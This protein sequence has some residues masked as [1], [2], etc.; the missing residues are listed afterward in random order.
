MKEYYRL[1]KPGI[2][3]GNA[4]TVVAGFI[5]A[6]QG[7]SNYLMLVL[8]VIGVS[9]VIASGCVFNN[10]FDR[11]IDAKMER[12]KNR[13]LVRGAIPLR[14]ALIYGTLLGIFGF[15]IL[16]LYTNIVTIAVALVGFLVYVIAYTMWFKRTTIY[17]VFVGSISGAVPLV[18]GYVAVTGRID[19]GAIILFIILAL[20][21]IPH[22]LA[23]SLYRLSDYKAA[24]IAVLPVAK[25]IQRTKREI[26][27]Y[28]ILFVIATLLLTPYGYTSWLY[29]HVMAI[30]G[31][32]F[33]L[34]AWRGL[35]IKN[36][37]DKVWARGVFMF[38]I[39][40]LVV[41]CLMLIVGGK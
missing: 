7:N 30:I 31:A 28:T 3:Y 13:A 9:L 11:D 4:I 19:S 36:L 2:V 39:F 22:S 21:Q 40:V 8:T 18:V 20:W 33:I 37:D 14:N 29:F 34:V 17:G 32:F 5:L 10:Y 24:H 23:I 12:T 41:F 38:S 27:L 1:V 26:V 35:Y 15:L 16:S 6:S 25:G